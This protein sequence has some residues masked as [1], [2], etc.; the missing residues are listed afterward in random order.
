MSWDYL[1]IFFKDVKICMWDT[2][3]ARHKAKE[4]LMFLRLQKGNN[5]VKYINFESGSKL[6]QKNQ[7]NNITL[8]HN[9]IVWP[10]L[11]DIQ[12]TKSHE[13]LVPLADKIFQNGQGK[14]KH[15]R[16]SNCMHKQLNMNCKIQGKNETINIVQ[17]IINI[18]KYNG[19]PVF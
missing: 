4:I 16:L 9:N 3:A 14:G 7:W 10:L 18:T 12:T 5:V 8:L 17:G 15:L 2:A 13:N 6:N 19:Q 11:G 1:Q